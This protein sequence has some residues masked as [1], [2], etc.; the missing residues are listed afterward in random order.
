[1][2]SRNERPANRSDPT[3]GGEERESAKDRPN[4]EPH[5]M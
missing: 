4:I 3:K 5:P 1:M 2:S